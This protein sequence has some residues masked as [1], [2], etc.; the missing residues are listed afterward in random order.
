MYQ[1][2]PEQQIHEPVR[3]YIKWTQGDEWMSIYIQSSY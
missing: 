2:C 3:G 1:I